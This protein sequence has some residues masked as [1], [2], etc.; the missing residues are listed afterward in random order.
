MKKQICSLLC[1][2]LLGLEAQA[3]VVDFQIE[4]TAFQVQKAE[5]IQEETLEAAPFINDQW[6]TMVP[7]RAISETFGA[8]IF[9]NDETQEVKISLKDTELLLYIGS[10][11]AF[12][13]GTAVT[14]DSAPVILEGR[15]FV[16]LRFVGEALSCNVNYASSSRHIIID[17]TEIAVRCGDSV[18]TFA[19]L[20]ALYDSIFQTNQAQ[21]E[22]MGMDKATLQNACLET[23][24]SQAFSIVWL[25]YAFPD[26]SLTP[27]ELTTVRI[28]AAL[29]A[30]PFAL[31]G[32]RDVLYEKMFFGRSVTRHIMATTDLQTLYK[33]NY[34]CAKH[35]LVKTEETAGEV[36]EKAVAG[37]DFDALIASYN[38]DPGMAQNPDGYVFTTG[39]MVAEFEKAAFAAAVGEITEPV[40]TDY[41]YHIIK[42][43]A[44]PPF[45]AN[46]EAII[47]SHLVNQTML[48]KGTPQ[49]EMDIPQLLQ[50]LG[51]SG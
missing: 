26:V 23:A 5:G 13:N 28:E 32:M 47:A 20:K 12:L 10:T 38:T 41:G 33:E 11:E 4:N 9:W 18:L 50:K 7:I 40:Y 46:T 19:E 24:I 44:L 3:A 30:V 21:A 48:E 31:E 17:N 1:A 51:I 35:I 39:E 6:R 25:D 14:L 22:A 15:T 27:E 34:V 45:D 37:E 36:Y 42:R 2:A 8:E 16:P 29:E 49:M 43:E